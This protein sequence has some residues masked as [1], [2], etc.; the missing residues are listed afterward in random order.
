MSFV[1]RVM[2]DPEEPTDMK[3]YEFVK[4][5]GEGAF[6]KAMLC[7]EKTTGEKVVIK[8]VSL[9]N[10]TPQ[11]RD[12]A[13]KESQV[14]A[15]LKHPSIIQ[16]RETFVEQ[17]CLNIV[18]E[19]A[20]KGDLS[21]QIRRAK[22]NHFPESKVLKWFAEI[23]A[24]VKY[25]H[26]RR[27]LHRDIKCQ[28]VFLMS[29]GHVKLGDF[30]IA[31]VLDFSSQFSETVVGTPSYLSPELV[32]GKPYNAKT[33]IWGLG[34]LLYELCAFHHAFEADNLNAMVVKILRQN[35]LPIP[36]MY[37]NEVRELI[38][39]CLKKKPQD[40]PTI[41][42]IL[43]LPFL[44]PYLRQSSDALGDAVVSGL[45]SGR[46]PPTKTAA[47][48]SE[49]AADEGEPRE[50]VVKRKRARIVKPFNTRVSREP[51]KPA[52]KEEILAMKSA[53]VQEERENQRLL[54][55]KKAE[56]ERIAAEK[57]EA[58]RLEIKEKMKKRAQE[59]IEKMKQLK[60][61]AS[62][63]EQRYKNL[64]APF[65]KAKGPIASEKKATEE[66]Q[67][68][69]KE[70]SDES[71]ETKKKL[72][73]TKV[74]AR[75]GKVKDREKE[76]QELRQLIAKKR[77]EMK[78][79]KKESAEKRDSVQIG[80]VEVPIE[81]QTSEKVAQEAPAQET[82]P[83]RKETPEQETTPKQKEAPARE[84]TPKRKEVPAK[85]EA[86]EVADEEE[87]KELSIIDMINMSSSDDEDEDDGKDI[88]TI[89]EMA[90]DIFG[91]PI[92]KKREKEQTDRELPP[93]EPK[94]K[95]VDRPRR[96]S[97]PVEDTP[98]SRKDDLNRTRFL[99]AGTE[100]HLPMVTDKD[101]L[102]YRAEAIRQFVENGIG[103]DRFM[104]AYEIM[105]R[106]DDA[107]ERRRKKRVERV[108]K[109]K[110]EME[111]YPLI[112][113]L[114]VCEESMNDPEYA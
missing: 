18:M 104:E 65:K 38:N 106:Q 73:K 100:L 6:A 10:L 29:D 7:T 80:N 27:I 4:V 47:K 94:E 75:P 68:S 111:Y 74:T 11:E 98:P 55:E 112:Q 57:T 58:K 84:K 51:Q 43:S 71:P 108:L 85:E 30:G 105:T 90:K 89:A 2:D 44:Q 21:R 48:K 3:N 107:S 81:K 50:T 92:K 9:A 61:E 66:P 52:T 82:T 99:F 20:E 72:V 35:P 93:S 77:A 34:C 60:A 88:Q 86:P 23:C 26:D 36:T 70:S 62:E 110:K 42:Q 97:R 37:S 96:V 13:W 46:S 49:T 109:T 56:E 14:H 102:N 95:P 45:A 64:E 103:L 22:R 5:V 63:R 19:Y 28:N 54:R 87:E 67:S 53:A 76:A 32:Q 39:H 41:D 31:K 79:A 8:K 33:D 69:A 17:G 24:G 40:R 91:T 15:M 59:R 114:I 16:L 25:L 78:K 113:Q 101:S 83:K 1:F 12:T